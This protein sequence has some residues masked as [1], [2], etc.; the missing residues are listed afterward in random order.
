L[1]NIFVC[2]QVDTLNK[3]NV[4]GKKDGYWLQ[5]LDSLTNPSDSVNA[6]FYGYELYDNGIKVFK[7]YE[8]SQIYKNYTLVYDG[9]FPSK[10][11]PILIDGTFKWYSNEVQ[12]ENIEIYKFGKP[13]YFKSY[14]YSINQLNSIF[15]EVL[16]FDKLYNGVIGTYYYEEYL[17][18]NLIRKYWYRKGRKKWKSFKI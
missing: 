4:N 3:F 13:H 7:F 14:V 16:Y 15:N 18:G 9:N 2:G 6:F 1:F 11:N 8:K 12:I 10:G 5:Y 17:N